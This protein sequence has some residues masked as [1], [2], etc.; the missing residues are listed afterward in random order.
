MIIIL[1]GCDTANEDFLKDE[2]LFQLL[3]FSRK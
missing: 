2:S 3:G 1:E